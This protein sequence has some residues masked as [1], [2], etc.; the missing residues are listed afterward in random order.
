MPHRTLIG[1]GSNLGD[2]RRQLADALDRLDA[3]DQIEVLNASNLV[4]SRPI[5]GPADQ[6]PFANGAALLATELSAAE[7]LAK[8]QIVESAL[9]R[10]REIEWGPRTLDLD[11]LLY[12]QEIMNLPGLVVPHPRL[13]VRSFVLEP[14]TEIAGDWVHPWINTPLGELWKTW[15]M[16]VDAVGLIGDATTRDS[17]RQLLTQLFP[18]LSSAEVLDS[19]VGNR[20]LAMVAIGDAKNDAKSEAKNEQQVPRIAFCTCPDAAIPGIPTLCVDFF[21]DQVARR[22]VAA[23]IID[24]WPSL[25]LSS[26]GA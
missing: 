7:L 8:L 19:K 16:G 10:V 5:G 9:G 2:S 13:A 25:G 21:D 18:K 24:A 4:D 14:A 12:G 11:L 15:R 20:E 6:P 23:A 26:T 3:L 22:D 17:L 1:L